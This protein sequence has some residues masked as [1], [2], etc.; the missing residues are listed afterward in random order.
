MTF[1]S[2]LRKWYHPNKFGGLKF[3]SLYSHISVSSHT[4]PALCLNFLKYWWNAFIRTVSYN[5]A[6]PSVFPYIKD[7]DVGKVVSVV[8]FFS[9]VNP[10]T[11]SRLNSSSIW[12]CT[13]KWPFNVKECPHDNLHLKRLGNFLLGM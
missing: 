11:C 12:Q 4:N 8:L 6:R 2:F 5:M 9:T 10:A 1:S 3:T 13:V 7:S